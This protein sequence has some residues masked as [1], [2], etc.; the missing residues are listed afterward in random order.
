MKN[1]SYRLTGERLVLALTLFVVLAVIAITA[2]ATV[3]A[4]VLFILAFVAMSYFL[5]RAHHQELL[6]L[7]DKVTPE[8]LPDLDRLVRRGAR[9]LRPGPVEVFVATGN[10]L[11]AY[12]FGLSSPKALVLYSG[13]LP[14][15]E[16][17]ELVF[18]LGHE[19]GHVALGHTWLNSLVGG[20]AGIPASWSVGTILSLVFLW[21]NRMCEYSADR[22]G[23]LACGNSEKAFSALVKLGAGP[24]ARTRADLE[25]AYRRIDA[26]DDTPAGALG[27]VLATHPLLIRRIDRLRQYARSDGYRRVLSS[28]DQASQI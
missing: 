3:C 6:S 9:R 1:T 19:M 24:S 14:L 25:Q 10:E 2:S 26:E 23:L 27:E 21:W 7:A 18:I 4:S 20:M 22:A 28:L 8:A 13:L 16:E 15:M 17:D 11:N 12:T 5:G